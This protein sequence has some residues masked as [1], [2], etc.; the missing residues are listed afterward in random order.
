VSN[1]R[2]AAG[3]PAAFAPKVPP[4]ADVQEKTLAEVI[5]ESV[6][7]H[8]GQLL[9]P[10]LAAIRQL[11]AMPACVICTQT[12]KQAEHAYQVALANA[13]RAAEPVPGAPVLPE[14]ALA[15]TWVPLGQPPQAVPVCYPHFPDGPQVRA[16]GLVDAQGNQ[17]LARN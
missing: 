7:L 14:I 1:T 8:L 5:G 13:G 2:H 11:Q 12:R 10:Q 4:S 17:I 9:G 3:V 16:V 6:A 15:V